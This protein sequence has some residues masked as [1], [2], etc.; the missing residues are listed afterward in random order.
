MSSMMHH[1]LVISCDQM[2]HHLVPRT[3][4]KPMR[5]GRRPVCPDAMGDEADF[6]D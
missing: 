2:G 4:A 6:A 1:T 5:R 3:K